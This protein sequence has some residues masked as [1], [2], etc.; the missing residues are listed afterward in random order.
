MNICVPDCKTADYQTVN[1]EI[2]KQCIYLGPFCSHSGMTID[3]ATG[4]LTPYCKYSFMMDKG[5]V[6]G[7]RYSIMNYMLYEANS[8]NFNTNMTYSKSI[9]ELRN[10]AEEYREPLS[11]SKKLVPDFDVEVVAR[12]ESPYCNLC[13]QFNLTQC[14]TCRGRFGKHSARHQGRCQEERRTC[15]INSKKLDQKTIEKFEKN[16][17]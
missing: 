1:D 7:S 13:E 2:S 5:F 11:F 17:Y 3:S 15:V 14:V 4:K 8:S 12:C 16:C 10:K 9:K 6:L